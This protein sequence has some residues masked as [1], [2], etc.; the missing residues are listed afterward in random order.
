M[1]KHNSL[2]LIS[3]KELDTMTSETA[4][5]VVIKTIEKIVEVPVETVKIVT[6]EKLVE[7]PLETIKYVDRIIEP[8]KEQQLSEQ[9]F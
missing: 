5:N 6:V 7:K 1:G 2:P 4:T 8:S 9:K 3:P